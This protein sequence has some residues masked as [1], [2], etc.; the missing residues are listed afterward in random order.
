MTHRIPPPGDFQI[1]VKPVGPLCN[2]ACRYCYYLP[3]GG[4][5]AS[6]LPMAEA[7]LENYIRQ[8]LETCPGE[9]VRFSW[10]GGEPTLAGIAYF[11]RI[12][13]IQ[14]KYLPTGKRVVNG[15]QTNGTL[16][17]DRW[18]R[19]LATHHF[20]VGLSLD[21]PEEIHNAYRR[22]RDGTGTFAGALAGWNCLQRHSVETDI[23]AVVSD[24]SVLYPLQVYRFFKQIGARHL[25]FLPLVE[26]EDGTPDGVSRQSVG[27]EEFGAF[28]CTIFDEWRERDIGRVK[29]QIFEEAARTAFDQEH[30]LC[31]FRPTC[32]DIPVLERNGD[33]FV[34]D[35][36][37]DPA[38]RVGNLMTQPLGELVDAPVIKTFGE[39]KRATLPASCRECD[40]L[41]MC[42]GECPKNRFVQVAGEPFPHNYLCAGYRLFFRHC[43]P[44]VDEVARQW[45]YESIGTR[46]V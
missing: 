36:Y 30:S 15:L 8:H 45:R 24:I 11:Q 39:A 7:V 19:F 28:L 3:D 6:P 22:R 25:S 9:Y 14:Q 2:L 1:F 31:L 12:V 41:L 5:P 4:L 29:V 17:D 13:E 34:C 46:R 35:H 26:R 37:V 32:G 42:H 33:L 10:H 16:L 44:F 21:G 40:V 27:P 23:L 18:G 38:F 20:T 43:R